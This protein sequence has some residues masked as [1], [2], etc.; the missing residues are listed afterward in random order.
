MWALLQGLVDTSTFS[1]HGICLLWEPSLI[2]L[3]V[4]SDAATAL[5]YFSIPFALSYFVAKRP[6]VEFGWVFWAFSIFILA[7]GFTHIFAIVTLWLP[8]YEL[9][10]IVKAMTAI[11]SVVTAAM[12]WPLLPKL[13]AV[14]S[15]A[16]L[17]EAQSALQ[18]ETLQRRDAED[19]LRQSLKMEAVGQLTGGVAHDFNNLLTIIIGNLEIA[20][21]DIGKLRDGVD[22]RLRRLVGSAMSGAQRAA[23][24]TSRLLAFAR[25]QPLDPK[26]CNLD[27]LLKGMA[28]FFRST[29]GETIDLEYVGTAGL[30]Q[31]EIDPSHFEAA[32]LNLVVNARDAMPDGGKLTIE[33]SNVYLDDDYASRHSEVVAGQYVQVA[34]TDTG[35]GMSADVVARAFEPYYT[36]KDVG[37]GTGL[38]L[39]QVYGFV[40]QSNGHVKIYSEVG[41]G[42]TMK[43]YLPRL[44]TAAIEQSVPDS[45]QVGAMQAEQI[46]V[47]EDDPDVRSYVVEVLHDLNYQVVQAP[48]A[49]AALAMA[50]KLDGGLD[51]LLTDVV[52]PGMNGRELADQLRE[53]RPDLKVLFMT[54]YSRNAI[55]HH[56]RLDAGVDLIQ[57]PLSQVA[58]AAKIRSVLDRR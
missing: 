18:T 37:Q 15:P 42:T 16:Q 14:P 48:D 36:T 13:L 44:H 53:Q 29:L 38:G 28:G 41:H 5:A 22:T 26:P 49:G 8:V 40:K 20:E 1:P 10:G 7:C 11:A 30:W 31:V 52:L 32:I 33:T 23:T 19:M 21:R 12:L 17:R 39:S 45:I 6:D 25:R 43:V 58:L 51:L 2:W 54:G 27:Q 4:A 47:V 57:K 9:E 35:S 24:L 46:L 55:V 34:V 50:E 56:G 3:H